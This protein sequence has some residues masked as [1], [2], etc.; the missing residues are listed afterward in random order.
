MRKRISKVLIVLINIYSFFY[1]SLFVTDYS[2]LL[3][4]GISNITGFTIIFLFL[5]FVAWKFN[6][7]NLSPASSLGSNLLLFRVIKALA[8]LND[9]ALLLV[10]FMGLGILF[11]VLG[12][13]RHIS[14]STTAWDMGIFDQALWNTLQG[15]ILFSSIRGNMSLLGD[16]FEPILFLLVPVYALFP[17]V[18]TLIVIQSFILSSSIFGLY[19]IAKDKLSSRFAIFALLISFCLS[20]ALRGIALADFHPDSFLV[21]LSIFAFYFLAKFKKLLLAFSILLILLCKET[22]VLIVI[23]LGIYS[24]FTLKKIRLGLILIVVGALS[25]LVETKVILPAFNSFG[26]YLFNVRM[27]FG[28][29]YW[30]NI[31]FVMKHPL[32]LIELFFIPQKIIFYLKLLGQVGYLAFFVP[33][34]YLLILITSSIIL[35]ASRQLH[36]Y[37]ML[38]SHYAAHFLPFIFIATIYGLSNLAMILKKN[39]FFSNLKS[40]A[41]IKYL[42]I[43]ILVMSL[44][45]FSKADGYKFRRFIDG[46]RINKPFPKLKYLSLVPPQATVSATANLVPHLSHRKYIYD[47]DPESELSLKTDYVIIDLSAT[48]YL[49]ESSKAKVDSF[50]INMEN[51]GFKRLVFN[52]ELS[53]FIFLNH[54]PDREFIEKY[55]ENRGIFGHE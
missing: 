42:S 4:K 54:K 1:F 2:F 47:W 30:E 52:K 49:S 32:K 29:T 33:S 37:Y 6:K 12:M 43:Y 51:Y 11:C 27:P 15:D 24:C 17:H 55:R 28:E 16:H 13:I 34:Q 9:K 35:L 38:T 45:F 8:G 26:Q 44:F 36:G 40:T 19:L 20:K 53:F 21:P 25:W 46:I 41:I 22:A 14:L 7:D 18:F 3:P 31:S 39:K 48:D 5:L 50:L 23:A 10:I